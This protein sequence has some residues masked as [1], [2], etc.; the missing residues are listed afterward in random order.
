MRFKHLINS[1]TTCIKTLR[2][3]SSSSSPQD[4]VFFLHAPNQYKTTS[5]EGSEHLLVIIQI[6]QF[7]KSR[8][9]GGSVTEIWLWRV[10]AVHF[11]IA[12]N[13]TAEPSH[14]LRQ[15]TGA[16][17]PASIWNSRCVSAGPFSG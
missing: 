12:V 14:P 15:E 9:R 1:S 16:G 10:F 13:S 2:W 4:P 5:S 17:C 6:M 3:T 7:F 8:Q 11:R